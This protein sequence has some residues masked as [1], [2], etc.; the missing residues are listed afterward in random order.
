[1]TDGLV[2]R[3]GVLR[4]IGVLRKGE[5]GVTLIEFALVLPVLILLFIG[6]V[7]FS[8]AFTVSRKLATTANTV[9]DLVAQEATVTTADLD[10]IELI[11]DEIMKPYSTTPLTL[12]IVSV[13]AD[14]SNTP[15]VD[16]SYP[17]TYATGTVYALPQADMTEAGSSLIIAEATY[18]FTPT[19]SQ[20]LGTF[21]INKRAFFRP[22]I[23]P[24]VSLN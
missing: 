3:F 18:G 6:L 20:F 15:R 11:A 23:A 19:V 7:E 2:P 4:T 10:N 5:R 24:S 21:N 1:M 13:V 22:R 16:W 14:S 9:S 8:E 17:T 12:V